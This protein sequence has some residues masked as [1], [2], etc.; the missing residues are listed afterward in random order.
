M[1]TKEQ[2]LINIKRDKN[3]ELEN[4]FNNLVNSGKEFAYGSGVLNVA[5]GRTVLS[6]LKGLHSFYSINGINDCKLRDP[7]TGRTVNGT[8]TEMETLITD[9]LNWGHNNYYININKQDYVHSC[10]NVEDVLDVTWESLEVSGI[11]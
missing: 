6:A 8:L 11:L 1:V 3:G 5:G 9:I 7:M 4:N 2:H 10:E